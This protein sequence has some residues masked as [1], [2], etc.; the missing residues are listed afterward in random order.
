MRPA[1]FLDRDGVL[2]ENRDHYVRSWDDV[3]FFAHTFEAMRRAAAWPHAFVVVSNQAGVGKGLIDYA[4]AETIN[5]R[6][7]ATVCERGGRIDR[8]YF[9]PHRADA[10]CDCRKPRPGML[11]RA[12]RELDLDLAR[13]WMIGDNLTDMQA[14]SAAGTRCLLVR[15][16]LGD[17]QLAALNEAA[18]DADSFE[19]ADN[20]ADALD[21]IARTMT[22][23]GAS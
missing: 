10:G 20:L 4:L 15:T 3:A 14:G 17:T 2:I 6:V 9:C 18:P 19:I 22:H 16:G 5:L 11:L 23:T 7:A 13:S 8:V 12:A 21:R 1:I